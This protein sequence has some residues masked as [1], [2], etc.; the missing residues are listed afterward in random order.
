LNLQAG[1]GPTPTIAFPGHF[2]PNSSQ[3]AQIAI[4]Y[5]WVLTRF[6]AN[7]G[8]NPDCG[9]GFFIKAASIRRFYTT[10]E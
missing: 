1:E 10:D 2:L 4:K 8:K 6:R 3:L 5:S 7:P 9:G